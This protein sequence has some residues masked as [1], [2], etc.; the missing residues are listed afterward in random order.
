MIRKV[1]LR[2]AVA[3]QRLNAECLVM[4]SIGTTEAQLKSY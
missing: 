1:K 2:D 3:I 4:T